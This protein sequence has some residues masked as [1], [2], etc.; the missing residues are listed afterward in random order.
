MA[1]AATDGRAVSTAHRRIAAHLWPVGRGVGPAGLPCPMPGAVF[2]A[3]GALG[4]RGR[5]FGPGGVLAVSGSGGLGF[6]GSAAVSRLSL[7]STLRRLGLTRTLARTLARTSAS[8][9]ARLCLGA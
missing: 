5:R 8:A 1:A 2:A 9:L 6:G 7:G 4:A 3:L